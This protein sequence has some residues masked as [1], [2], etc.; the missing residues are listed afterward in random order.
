M[1]CICMCILISEIHKNSKLFDFTNHKGAKSTPNILFILQV[2]FVYFL[3]CGDLSCRVYFYKLYTFCLIKFGFVLTLFYLFYW[4]RKR[5]TFLNKKMS[6]TSIWASPSTPLFFSL[7][8]RSRSAHPARLTSRPRVRAF[9]YFAVTNRWDPL[10]APTPPSTSS[11]IH[12]PKNGRRHR[13]R[14]PLQYGD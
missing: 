6:Q 10:S 2:L 9:F 3:I 1:H 5:K 12:L 4:K 8:R 11:A 14:S 13:R 7:A